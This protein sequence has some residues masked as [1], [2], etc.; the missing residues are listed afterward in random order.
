MLLASSKRTSFY[1]VSPSWGYWIGGRS[2]ILFSRAGKQSFLGV[3]VSEGKDLSLVHFESNK[4]TCL[5]FIGEEGVCMY[6]VDKS[7]GAL[8]CLAHLLGEEGETPPE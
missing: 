6:A 5:T 7:K 1:K 4:A 2:L 8:N 3:Y